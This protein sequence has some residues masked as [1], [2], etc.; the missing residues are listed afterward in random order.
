MQFFC[1]IFSQKGIIIYVA[2]MW[3]NKKNLFVN[4]KLTNLKEV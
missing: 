2:I 4:K 1:D 3:S